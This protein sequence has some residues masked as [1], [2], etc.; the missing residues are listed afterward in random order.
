[1]AEHQVMRRFLSH[2]N[3]LCDFVSHTLTLIGSHPADLTRFVSKP[4]YAFLNIS[5][6]VFDFC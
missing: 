4:F 1:M 6:D 3:Y 2:D 5:K